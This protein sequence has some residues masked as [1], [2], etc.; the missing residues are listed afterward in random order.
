[1]TFQMGAGPALRK[2]A[3]IGVVHAP[4]HGA[5]EEALTENTFREKGLCT[6][7]QGLP[8]AGVITGGGMRGL[9]R[10][11]TSTLGSFHGPVTL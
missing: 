8:A 7:S 2:P 6:A 11:I 3:G 9:S 4:G 10:S 1:M 5:R